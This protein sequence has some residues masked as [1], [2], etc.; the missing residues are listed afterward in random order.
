M[1][2]LIKALSCILSILILL[3]TPVLGTSATSSK[4]TNITAVNGQ[5]ACTVTITLKNSRGVCAKDFNLNYSINGETEKP[6]KI[7][8]FKQCDKTVTI[9]SSAFKAAKF[10]QKVTITEKK[11]NKSTTFIVPAT[12]YSV[13][14]PPAPSGNI[15]IEAKE[16]FDF[17]ADDFEVHDTYGNKLGSQDGSF[18]IRVSVVPPNFTK[19]G[20]TITADASAVSSER[21]D[22]SVEVTNGTGAVVFKTLVF[23]ML[24]EK[25]EPVETTLDMLELQPRML[26]VYDQFGSVDNDLTGRKPALADE[27]KEVLAAPPYLENPYLPSINQSAASNANTWRTPGANWNSN[28]TTAVLNLLRSCRINK[29]WFYDGPVYAPSTYTADGSAPYEVMGGTLKIY[30][31]AQELAAYT[32]TNEGKWV[33]VDLGAA[34]IET[35]TLRFVK[36]QDLVNNRYSWSGGGW[37]SPKGEYICDVNIPEIA[38]YGKSLGEI[39]PDDT[40]DE[41]PGLTPS[42]KEPTDFDFTFSEFMGAN[43]FFNETLGNYDAVGF[44]REYHSWGWTEWAAADQTAADGTKNYTGVD[45][46]PRTAFIDPWGG[47]FD[48]YYRSLKEKGIGVNICVQGGVSNVPSGKT[49]RPNYQG[50]T[51]KYKASSYLAHGQSMF[52][53]AARY[54]S[55]PDVN[56]ALIRVAPGTVPKI[57]LDYIKYYE[58]WN[59]PNLGS[60]KGDGAAF[61]A[62]TSADYDGHMGTMGPDVGI[63]QADPNAKLVLGGL[64]GIIYDTMDTPGKEWT[65][66]E[67][68]EQMIEWFDK[69]RTEEKWLETHDTLDGYIKYP[70]DVLNGHYYAPDGYAGTGLSAEADHVYRR[71]SEFK[72]FRDT[73]FPDV[74]LWL[75][76]FGWDSTQGSSQSATVEYTDP[77]KGVVNQGI[78]TGLTGKEVQGRWLVREYLILEAAGLDRVQQFMLPNSGGG[79]GSSG[80]FD[81]CGLL[82]SESIRKPSWYYVGTMKFYL[83]STKFDSII[84]NG[85]ETDPW[86]L[87]FKETSDNGTDSIYALWL[88]TSKGDMNGTNSVNYA[89]TLPAGTEHAYVVKLKD[90]TL[91]G[92]RTELEIVDGK[93]TVPVSESPVFVLANREE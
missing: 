31:G 69:N 71:M 14:Y 81:T 30:N 12:E 16:P 59:E 29:I 24:V 67:F 15:T 55:N 48:N 45:A 62:M 57:G 8:S 43:G 52:Q 23:H 92:E 72:T 88:P 87:K 7:L 77:V 2:K 36:E 78:N 60:F 5:S 32:V 28:T 1:R 10:V 68:L 73:Y 53:L 63:K 86:V 41:W 27:Q 85:G 39:P 49:S 82:E 65:F 70:F 91:E 75:S 11:E 76:E 3:T 56:P 42:D 89:L 40:G 84:A 66:R 47:V 83:A 21:A 13:T 34:G 74:E 50:D 51:D 64:A 58:N 20:S 4:I 61:A 6:F 79:E 22:V 33:G 46:N 18:A 25:A 54:G 17:S 37:T 90:K 44:V 80:R 93:V 38:L 26:Y 35:N 9:K 19:T